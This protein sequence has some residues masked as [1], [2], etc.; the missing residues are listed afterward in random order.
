MPS[1][2]WRYISR[3][4]H[5]KL[6]IPRSIR[7]VEEKWRLFLTALNYYLIFNLGICW[8]FCKELLRK[9]HHLY[10]Y[11]SWCNLLNALILR[12]LFG[13]IYVIGLVDEEIILMEVCLAIPF[14]SIL[15]WQRHT[16]LTG[17]SLHLL[18]LEYLAKERG[19]TQIAQNEVHNGVFLGEVHLSRSYFWNRSWVFA[20]F[21]GLWFSPGRIFKEKFCR[22]I[23]I[24]F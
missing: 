13:Q 24:L 15:S 2:R 8:I 21:H 11:F 1:M 5:P 20:H 4:I 6:S 22:I 17:V 14:S 23:K 12:K 19:W 18:F 16:S 10:V 9:M 3:K 7:I